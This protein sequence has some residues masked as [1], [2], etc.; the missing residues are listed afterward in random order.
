MRLRSRLLWVVSCLVFITNVYGEESPLRTIQVSQKISQI[1]QRKLQWRSFREIG[2]KVQYRLTE[3]QVDTLA[4]TLHQETGRCGGF[5]DISEGE[6][7]IAPTPFT[8]PLK[9][10]SP[11]NSLAPVRP[12]HLPDEPVEQNI[13]TAVIKL[14]SFPTRH[15]ASDSG[16]AAA[17]WLKEMMEEVK[18]R[19]GRTD[20]DVEL[21]A[22]KSL[23]HWNWKMPSVVATIR[24]ESDERVIL[25]AHL[26]SINY[27]AGFTKEKIA[28]GADDDASG[29]A[30]MLEV[31]RLVVESKIPPKKTIQFMA[32]SGEEVGLL[33]SQAIAK[34]YRKDGVSVSAVMQFDM[35]NYPETDRAVYFIEDHV[36]SKLTAY[37]KNLAKNELKM[38][39]KRTLCG[40][41]CSDHAS[42][43]S[44]GFP[45]VFP[46]E[47]TA[48]NSNPFIHTKDDTLANAPYTDHAAKYA[49]I[50]VHFFQ[51]LA[52]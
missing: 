10:K 52:F 16:K 8:L 9:V 5:M 39:V 28:P 42:W 14:S 15:Y 33:G 37:V 31:Y 27:S 34:Q 12:V 11:K 26:D 21:I 35:L 1:I 48:E 44:A 19:T 41:A 47:S 46:F 7:N 29:V 2:D 22:H 49:K 17:E 40:Y 4:S 36:D 45:S 51:E 13:R 32:Y 20:V 3:E 23:V 18:N 38:D 6:M 50:A 30:T 43:T 25:G 24:G